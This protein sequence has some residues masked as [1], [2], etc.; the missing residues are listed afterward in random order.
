MSHIVSFDVFS[1]R[2]VLLTRVKSVAENTKRSFQGVLDASPVQKS[3]E[4]GVG[5]HPLWVLF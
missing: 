5:F 1:S 2:S 3:H 4:R